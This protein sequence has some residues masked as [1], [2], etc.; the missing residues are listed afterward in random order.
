[1]T[2]LSPTRRLQ[3]AA[4]AAAAIAAGTLV[5]AAPAAQAARPGAHCTTPKLAAGW[6]GDNQARL[7]QLIDRYGSCNPYRPGREKPVAV[8]D[9]D[10]TVV[11]NDVGD[12]T[13]FWL[14]RNGKIR[15]PAGGDWTTTSRYLTPAAAQALATACGPL[16]RPGAPLPTGTPAGA[17]CADE[18]NAVYGTAAT[19]TGAAAFAGWDHRTIEPAYA[20]LPQLTQGWTASEVRGFAAAARTENLAAPVGTKQQVGTTT[21]TGWVRYYDQQRDLVKGLQKAGFDVWISSASPQPVV[22]VWAQGVGVKADHVIGIRNTTR[23]GKLTAHLQGCGSVK[24]GADTM[25]T[26]IDGKRCWINKAVFGVRGPAAE[27]VQPASRRQVFAAGDSDT[28]ISFLRDATALRLVVNRNKNELMC[29]AYD[30]SDGKWIVNPMFIEPKKQKTSPYPCSTTGYT[31]HDGT[32]GPVRRG[33]T[34]VIPDQTDSV[35]QN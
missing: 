24:D 7:Q 29:R 30:N 19:R 34:S 28:D 23:N 32:A 10:N 9:W 3:A 25:I 17:P 22:E 18:L 12:A 13:M 31:D 5:A 8:F 11:K 1:M 4:V 35:F 26:Y 16:A 33:D 15:Q 6:Y 27:K 20:W 21:A 14:L 2:R